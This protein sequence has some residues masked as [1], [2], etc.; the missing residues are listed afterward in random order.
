MRVRIKIRGSREN[1][2]LK[3]KTAKRESNSRFLLTHV[4]LSYQKLALKQGHFT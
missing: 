1:N 2:L 3:L 4:E